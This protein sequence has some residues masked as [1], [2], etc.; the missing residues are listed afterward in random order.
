MLTNKVVQKA[1][2]LRYWA[3][4]RRGGRHSFSGGPP[5]EVPKLILKPKSKGQILARALRKI[6]YQVTIA[7]INRVT[8]TNGI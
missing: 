2:S 6:G 7:P 1:D 8:A 5:N 4:Q 3:L